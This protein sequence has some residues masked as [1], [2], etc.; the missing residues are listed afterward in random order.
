M[1]GMACSEDNFTHGQADD[2]I[3]FE[4]ERLDLSYS[5]RLMAG[6]VKEIRVL[7]VFIAIIFS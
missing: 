2:G 7:I 3:S 5:K 1:A 6:K 4:F